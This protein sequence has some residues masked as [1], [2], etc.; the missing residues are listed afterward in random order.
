MKALATKEKLILKV[1]ETIIMDMKHGDLSPVE[2]LLNHL[3]S[4]TLIDFL[5]E[6][7][8]KNFKHLND[9]IRRISN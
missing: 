1:I 4:E 7:D 2:E 8:F 5:P 9:E 6:K 3:P